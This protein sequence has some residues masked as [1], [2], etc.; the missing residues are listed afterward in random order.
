MR[1]GNKEQPQSKLT[2]SWMNVPT[3]EANVW[4]CQWKD[5]IC[6]IKLLLERV[7]C[8]TNWL[9]YFLILPWTMWKSWAVFWENRVVSWGKFHKKTNKVYHNKWYVV[10]I[11][12][13]TT[14][15]WGRSLSCR[16]FRWPAL[17]CKDCSI[18]LSNPGL[19]NPHPVV[20]LLLL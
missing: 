8:S 16:E 3:T 10:H 1:V 20:F 2:S 19:W 11:I 14:S 12:F 6:R 4:F 7:T 18:Q 17:V 5:S 15:L 9:L 13:C